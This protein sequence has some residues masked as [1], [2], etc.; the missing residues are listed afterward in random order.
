MAFFDEI[1]KRVNSVTQNAQKA[2]EIVRIQRQISLKQGEYSKLFAEIGKL[3]YSAYQNGTA[4]E[5]ELANLCARLDALNA[6][7]DGLNLKLDDVKQIRRCPKCGN[8]QESDNR[9]CA[10]CGEKLPERVIP[11][12]DPEIVMQDAPAQPE[13]PVVTEDDFNKSVQILWPEAETEQN[14]SRNNEQY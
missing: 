13:A 3:Y 7:I 5:D 12:Q 14:D 11:A 4:V 10:F 9:F 8:V 6:E 2:A 1:S